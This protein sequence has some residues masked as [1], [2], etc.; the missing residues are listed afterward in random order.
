[1]PPIKNLGMPFFPA[2][3]ISSRTPGFSLERFLM[4][5]EVGDILVDFDARSGHNHGTKFRFKNNRLPELYENVDV[6]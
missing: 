2:I 1:M 5:L 4:A 3:S 6:I